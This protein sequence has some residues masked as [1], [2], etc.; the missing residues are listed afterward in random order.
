M[1]GKV[2]QPGFSL[3]DRG[4]VRR[5]SGGATQAWAASWTVT[6]VTIEIG[7]AALAI[8]VEFADHGP[9]ERPLDRV[10]GPAGADGHAGRFHGPWRRPADGLGATIEISD[11]EA[12]DKVEFEFVDQS[13][14]QLCLKSSSF[15][16]SPLE[17]FDFSFVQTLAHFLVSKGKLTN[18]KEG[19]REGEVDRKVV[20]K[21]VA[22]RTLV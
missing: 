19:D 22:T 10:F 6:D 21:K 13:C 8:R 4:R 16:R 20:P 17:V 7:D 3:G 18:R 15:S 12:E 14:L 11:V 1:T 5:S 2:V 9:Q